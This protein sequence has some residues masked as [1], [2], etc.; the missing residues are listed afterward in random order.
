MSVVIQQYIRAEACSNLVWKT[1][2]EATSSGGLISKL[3]KPEFTASRSERFPN[4][5]K[6]K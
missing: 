4:T 5:E 3:E 6:K 1:Y 2:F